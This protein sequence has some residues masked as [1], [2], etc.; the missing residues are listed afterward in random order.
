MGGE[1]V[2]GL[3]GSGKSSIAFDTLARESRRQMTLNYPLYVRN[4]MP[5]YEKTDPDKITW[6]DRTL[7]EWG[8]SDKKKRK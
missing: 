5:R 4:Q 1:D 6:Y 7:L 3:S 8:D 2:N